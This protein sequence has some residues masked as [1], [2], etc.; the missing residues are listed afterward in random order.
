MIQQQFKEHHMTKSAV[1]LNTIT[2]END[3]DFKRQFNKQVVNMK[4]L[5]FYTQFQQRK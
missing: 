3:T 1:F 5:T 2:I 4:S